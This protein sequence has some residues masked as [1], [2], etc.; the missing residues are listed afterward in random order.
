MEITRPSSEG[1]GLGAHN[2]GGVDAQHPTFLA[3]KPRQRIRPGA[4][5]TEPEKENRRHEAAD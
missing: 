4:A 5:V 2:K 1:R 3:R